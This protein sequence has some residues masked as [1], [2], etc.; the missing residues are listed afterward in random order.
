MKPAAG[1]TKKRDEA[2]DVF[3]RAIRPTRTRLLMKSA[4]AVF[5]SGSRPSLSS[6]GVSMAEGTTAFTRI[7]RG[8]SSNR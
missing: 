6:A 7:R 8:A 2:R 3:R 5:V 1:E 4:K